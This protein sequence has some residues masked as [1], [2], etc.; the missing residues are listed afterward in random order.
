MLGELGL[1]LWQATSSASGATARTVSRA[2]ST[3]AFVAAGVPARGSAI[4]AL[5]LGIGDLAPAAV[6]DRIDAP[7]KQGASSRLVLA[8]IVRRGPNGLSLLRAPS[9]V[10]WAGLAAAPVTTMR[11]RPCAA[12]LGSPGGLGVAWTQAPETGLRGEAARALVRLLASLVRKVVDRG[13]RGMGRRRSHGDRGSRLGLVLLRDSRPR[14]S[15]AFRGGLGGPGVRRKGR[16]R[17][18]CWYRCW[19]FGANRDGAGRSGWR[20]RGQRCRREGESRASPAETA[21][22]QPGQHQ[23]HDRTPRRRRP[24]TTAAGTAA[25]PPR[26][27]PRPRGLGLVG[28]RRLGLEHR[29]GRPARGERRDCGLPEPRAGG[30]RG[31]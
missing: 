16:R 2:L 24:E 3:M 13:S 8:E 9:A 28:G 21:V 18:R 19:R 27:A 7:R 15:G 31:G 26:L 6:V 23:D 12:P 20:R 14:L 10:Q 25:K 11:S 17:R 22:G 1:R 30:G 5:G 29:I 4:G